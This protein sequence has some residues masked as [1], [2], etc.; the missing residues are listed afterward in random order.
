MKI[1]IKILVSALLL[2]AFIN[3]W[4]HTSKRDVKELQIEAPEYL[5]DMGYTIKKYDG[6]ETE[7]SHGGSVWYIV[8]EDSFIYSL[9]VSKW[10]GEL[11]I[12]NRKCLNA[13]SK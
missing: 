12:Y 5:K 3:S 13:L 2:F 11:M 6:W 8:E 4:Y 7:I 10:R 9:S 1:T